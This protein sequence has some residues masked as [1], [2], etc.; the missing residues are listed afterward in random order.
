MRNIEPLPSG[1]AMSSKPRI[2]EETLAQQLEAGY[3]LDL[4]HW[5]AHRSNPINASDDQYV[6]EYRHGDSGRSPYFTNWDGEQRQPRLMFD[7]DAT[8]MRALDWNQVVGLV[9]DF[10]YPGHSRRHMH[11]LASP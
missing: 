5:R 9:D 2:D 6:A 3:F 7:P 4:W 8:G 1:P 11:G 10:D